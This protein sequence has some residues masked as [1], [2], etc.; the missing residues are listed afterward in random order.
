MPSELIPDWGADPRVRALMTTR[1]NGDLR[2][3]AGTREAL[4][5]AM[6]A[7]GVWLR[8]VHGARVVRVGRADPDLAAHEA[9]AL[10]LIH[11]S[12]PTRH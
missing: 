4:E 3:G 5:S 11:I 9:D 8:Q 6:G 7:R 2:G 10:S 12:E 1:A